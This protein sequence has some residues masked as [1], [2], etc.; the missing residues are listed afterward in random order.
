MYDLDLAAYLSMRG[1]ALAESYRDG[2]EFLFTFL[3]TDTKIPQT[4]IEYVN[5]EAARFADSVRRLKK[6]TLSQPR[7]W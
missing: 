5:S 2:R 4:V 1:I 3:D 6:V 7:R